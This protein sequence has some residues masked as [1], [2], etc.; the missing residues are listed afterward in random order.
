MVF[1]LFIT[2]S[3]TSS[4]LYHPLYLQLSPSSQSLLY[5][6]SSIIYFRVLLKWLVEQP[7]LFASFCTQPVYLLL[8]GR[9]ATAVPCV[10]CKLSSTLSVR[11]SVM[12]QRQ[13]L[14]L[15]QN[16]PLALG[17]TLGQCTAP[18]ILANE[19]KQQVH[20]IKTG[21]AARMDS[22]TIFTI[23]FSVHSYL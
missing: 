17:T 21:W 14:H 23:T 18:G 10:N 4:L 12:R 19:N 1:L 16:R 22:I 2:H 9:A 8:F 6:Q 5:R 13:S 20:G 3:S 15:T 11:T 7:P